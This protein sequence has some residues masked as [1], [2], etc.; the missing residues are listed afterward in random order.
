M[1]RKRVQPPYKRSRITGV[2]KQKG[3]RFPWVPAPPA[4]ETEFLE[5]EVEMGEVEKAMVKSK[6]DAKHTLD[7]LRW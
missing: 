5:K 6:E 4:Y 3:P 7:A 1:L 2:G